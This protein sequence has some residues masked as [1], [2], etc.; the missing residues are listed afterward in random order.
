MKFGCSAYA[1]AYEHGLLRVHM[2]SHT[3][4]DRMNQQYYMMDVTAAGMHKLK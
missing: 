1:C 3:F 2:S 4:D